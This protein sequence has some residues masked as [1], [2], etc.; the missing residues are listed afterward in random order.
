MGDGASDAVRWDCWN[1]ILTSHEMKRRERGLFTPLYVSPS[2]LSMNT[3]ETK[4]RTSTK[5]KKKYKRSVSAVT[6]TL[7]VYLL[8]LL[9]Q[10]AANCCVFEEDILFLSLL[11]LSW[12]K[13]D[14]NIMQIFIYVR[15]KNAILLACNLQLP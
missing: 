5:R 11:F 13:W 3:I 1:R 14:T 15:A 12:N 9:L 7:F 4:E 8:V 10:R 2:S 6:Q